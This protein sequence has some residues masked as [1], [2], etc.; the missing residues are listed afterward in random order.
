MKCAL[1]N[2]K[3]LPRRTWPGSGK[4]W[5]RYKSDQ[6]DGFGLHPVTQIG[7]LGD[8]VTI[9]KDIWISRSKPCRF[10]RKGGAMVIGLDQRAR[11]YKERVM[12]KS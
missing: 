5:F 2:K 1:C 10:I 12:R 11:C 9:S 6:L 8:R 4:V 7:Q 3:G